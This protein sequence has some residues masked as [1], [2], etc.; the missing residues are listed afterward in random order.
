MGPTWGPSGADRAQLGPMLAPW[1]LLSGKATLDSNNS[2][3]PI[4]QQATIHA[5]AG[6]LFIGNL[7]SKIWIKHN[8]FQTRKWIWICRLQNGDYFV[9]A[10]KCLLS[11]WNPCHRG[12]KTYQCGHRLHSQ[13]LCYK[14]MGKATRPMGKDQST[15]HFNFEIKIYDI[16]RK[17]TGVHISMALKYNIT[18]IWNQ[19]IYIYMVSIYQW[20]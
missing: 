3:S 1:T 16:S 18:S 20:Y 8:H 14:T 6:F 2:W 12:K 9:F 15:L 17:L 7:F 5:N 11:A 10:W 4:R 13:A 19:F